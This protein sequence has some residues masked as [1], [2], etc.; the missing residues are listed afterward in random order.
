[1]QVHIIKATVEETA[2]YSGLE[3][4]AVEFVIEKKTLTN[5][6]IT[7]TADQT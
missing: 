3:S 5:D 2:D 6:N 7:D 1:M 4:D